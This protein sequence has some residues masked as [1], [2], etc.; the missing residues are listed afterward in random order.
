[1]AEGDLIRIIPTVASTM[2]AGAWRY[3]SRTDGNRCDSTGTTS[4]HAGCDLVRS[5]ASRP[6]RSTALARAEME[7]LDK[8]E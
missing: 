1:M 4:S 5:P 6:S 7:R 3:G 2:T 8:S